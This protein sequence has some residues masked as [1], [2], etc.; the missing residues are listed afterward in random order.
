M[1]CSSSASLNEFEQFAITAF[2]CHFVVVR[3]DA[4]RS[5]PESLEHLAFCCIH[6]DRIDPF[7]SQFVSRLQ[8]SV[9]QGRIVLAGGLQRV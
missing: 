5:E 9:G 7:D 8:A 1:V 2:L 3:Q 4:A 6:A